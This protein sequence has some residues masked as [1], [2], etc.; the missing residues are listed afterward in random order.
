MFRAFGVKTIDPPKPGPLSRHPPLL[1]WPHGLADDTADTVD[2]AV[3]TG[4][5][6]TYNSSETLGRSSTVAAREQRIRMEEAVLQ[7]VLV[8]SEEENVV[9]LFRCKD[10][11]F[12][13]YDAEQN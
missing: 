12:V 7:T 13:P 1:G 5:N 10:T 8:G 3:V 6:F 4:S 11:G 2:T 9:L